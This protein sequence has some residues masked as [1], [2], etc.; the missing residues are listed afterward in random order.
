MNMSDVIRQFPDVLTEDQCISIID[1]YENNGNDWNNLDGL[2]F[3]AMRIPIQEYVFSF[4]DDFD[5]RSINCMDTGYSMT[6]TQGDVG[7]CIKSDY[8]FTSIPN[9]NF[10]STRNIFCSVV[11]ES[12]FNYIIFLN[13]PVGGRTVIHIGNERHYFEPEVGKV[14]MFPTYPFYKY[15][16]EAVLEGSKY[17]LGGYTTADRVATCVRL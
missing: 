16:E 11:R 13:K 14:L 8:V 5:F 10:I 12:L 6:K 4:M 17:V 9:L 2:I 7:S 15:S 1:N 3:E